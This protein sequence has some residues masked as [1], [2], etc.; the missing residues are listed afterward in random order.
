[1]KVCTRAFSIRQQNII[2]KISIMYN[3][4]MYTI[5]ILIKS[6]TKKQDIFLTCILQCVLVQTFH[7]VQVYFYECIKLRKAYALW[8]S[9]FDL[10]CWLQI[11]FL[12]CGDLSHSVELKHCWG[13]M[14]DCWRLLSAH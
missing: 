5:H 11:S 4:K 8:S 14:M 3:Y 7:L 10:L 6:K 9:V 12:R 13:M 2:V 1:M